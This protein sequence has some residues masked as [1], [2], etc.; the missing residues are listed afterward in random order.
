MFEIGEYITVAGEGL[1]LI[2]HGD[3][4][5]VGINNER[6]VFLCLNPTQLIPTLHRVGYLHNAPMPP[7]DSTDHD[8]F[9]WDEWAKSV[10]VMVDEEG[11]D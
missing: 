5:L 10:R 9:D 6:E 11:F 3:H 7:D 1:Y 2:A 8:S 4:V